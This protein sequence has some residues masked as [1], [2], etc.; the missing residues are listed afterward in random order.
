MRSNR[1]YL[2]KCYK[3]DFFLVIALYLSL[4]NI[5]TLPFANLLRDVLVIILFLYIT[6]NF[7]RLV[8]GGNKTIGFLVFAYSVWMVIDSFFYNEYM[9]LA[10]VN[11]FLNSIIKSFTVFECIFVVDIYYKKRGFSR[12]LDILFA[13]IGIMFV[14]SNGWIIISGFEKVLGDYYLVGTKFSSSYINF[15]FIVLIFFKYHYYEKK[16]N[17]VGLALLAIFSI[18][19]IIKL[20][21]SSALVALF[22][23]GIFLL[24]RFQLQNFFP[25]RIIYL[26]CFAAIFL[27]IY[28]YNIVLNNA[29]VEHIIVDIL[30]ESLTMTGRTHVYKILPE[31]I[32]G[33]WLTGFGSGRTGLI[34]SYYTG[35]SNAQNGVWQIICE[36]GLIGFILYALTCLKLC[37]NTCKEKVSVSYYLNIYVVIMF[38]LGFVEITFDT[39][40]LVLL[41]I[42]YL[43]ND[44][45]PK[46]IES[47]NG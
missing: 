35:C 11:S 5:I 26:L 36:N 37:S 34:L 1:P 17:Y 24:F 33:K 18:F 45:S 31:M 38:V 30:G 16:I 10:N 32:S 4:F 40:L 20:D 3:D 41:F 25:N 44:N 6:L 42:I 15:L 46:I 9:H 22:L 28:F 2:S 39:R 7:K 47:I 43:Y 27:F 13:Y 21:C 12:L 14:L 23:L 8:Q 19:I 29:Y